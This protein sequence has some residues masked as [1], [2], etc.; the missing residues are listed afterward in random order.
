MEYINLQTNFKNHD[1][2][3]YPVA[4]LEKRAFNENIAQ[5]SIF[6]GC[7]KCR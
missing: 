5:A 6:E 1:S 2:L 7:E 4:N 3:F